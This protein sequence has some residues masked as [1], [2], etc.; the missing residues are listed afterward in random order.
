MYLCR[1]FRSLVASTVLILV[2]RL[3][4]L[5]CQSTS[6]PDDG[7]EA[8][9]AAAWGTPTPTIG[10]QNESAPELVGRIRDVY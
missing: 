8:Q 4:L 1:P 7:A 5:S 2:G 9:L 6:G 3:L 10:A